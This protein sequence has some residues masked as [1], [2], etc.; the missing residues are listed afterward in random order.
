MSTRIK[1]GTTTFQCPEQAAE[2]VAPYRGARE[3][4]KITVVGTATDVK[5]AFVD[6]V[7]YTEEWDSVTRVPVL[8]EQG[9][10]VLDAQGQPTFTETTTVETRD[11]WDYTIA[12]DVVDT[13]DGNVTVFMGRKTPMELLMEENA[14]LLFENLTGEEF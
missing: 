8:D 13:R 12:G 4:R 10:P 14:A 5:A 7:M 9:A 1:I 3:W 11:L 2:P 6:G